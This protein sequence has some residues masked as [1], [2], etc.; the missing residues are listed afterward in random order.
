MVVKD[1]I[2]ILVKLAAMFGI[3]I[4]VYRPMCPLSIEFFV[5]ISIFLNSNLTDCRAIDNLQSH[6]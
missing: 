2:N 3:S 4:C 1:T 5:I 6:K